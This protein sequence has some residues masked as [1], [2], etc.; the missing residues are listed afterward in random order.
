MVGKENTAVCLGSPAAT[1]SFL[2]IKKE[3]VLLETKSWYGLSTKPSIQCAKALLENMLQ[4][5][6]TII[7]KTVFE[8]HSLQQEQMNALLFGVTFCV[9]T[10][11]NSRKFRISFQYSLNH[12]RMKSYL[13][14]RMCFSYTLE[15]AFP[16]PSLKRTDIN[17]VQHVTHLPWKFPR[18]LVRDLL[19]QNS[20]T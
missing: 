15:N 1:W 14:L 12:R 17:K 5:V 6:K 13:Y 8:E 20:C 2:L 19:C 4:K 7:L 18:Q 3:L 10:H 9:E 16:C 11:W